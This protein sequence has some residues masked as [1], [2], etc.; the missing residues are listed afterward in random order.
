M[1]KTQ[2]ET[3]KKHNNSLFSEQTFNTNFV[4]KISATP[5]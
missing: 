5:T 3:L 2:N 1:R 4:I